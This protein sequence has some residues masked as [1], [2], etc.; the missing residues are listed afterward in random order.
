M[1]INYDVLNYALR[2]FNKY[3]QGPMIL[4]DIS[5]LYVPTLIICGEKDIRPN[6]PA[7]QVSNLL[8]VAM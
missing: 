4:K 2:S 7:I 5:M 6:W 8:P 1:E 3:I